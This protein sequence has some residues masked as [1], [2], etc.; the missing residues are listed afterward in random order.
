MWIYVKDKFN[1]SNKAW[2][3]LGTQTKQTPNN[4]KIEKKLKELNAKWN[5]QPTPGQPD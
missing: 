3:E 5:L 4:Y 1:I 2:H